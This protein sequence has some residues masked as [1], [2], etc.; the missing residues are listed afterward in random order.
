MLFN[1]LKRDL[2]RKKTMNCILFLFSILVSMFV[3]SGVNNVVTVMN[4]TDYF[5]EKAGIGDY[6][7]ITQNGDGGV[8]DIL[9]NSDNQEGYRIEES[10]F[11]S[12]E[13]IVSE[14]KELNM[15][16]NITLVQSVKNGGINYFLEDNSVLRD[17]NKGEIYVSIALMNKNDLSVGDTIK[18]EIGNI[19]G[20]FKIAGGIK[21]ALMGSEM[22]G[23][24]RIILNDEDYGKFAGDPSVEA[25]KGCIFYIETEN[26]KELSAELTAGKNVLFENG[27]DTIK[28]L[29]VMDMILAIIVLVLSIC[30]IIV[31]FVLLKFVITFTINEEYR[32][33]GVM[34]A[35][36][37][38]NTKIRGLYMI[39]YFFI[40]VAGGL[41]G[42]LL[43]IPFGNMLIRAASEKMY[44]GND[45]GYIYNIA[46][47]LIVVIIMVGFAYICTGKV[48]K[49]SPVD[50]IRNGHTGERFKKKTIYSLKKA[51]TSSVWYMAINDILSAPKRFITIVA[52]FFLCSIFVLGIVLVT[53]TMNS[54]NLITL[55]GKESDVYIPDSGLVK[56]ESM[57]EGGE[58]ILDEVK[59]DISNRLEKENMPATVSIEVWYKYTCYVDGEQYSLVLQKNSGTKTE[60]YEYIEG[61]APENPDEIAIT[62]GISEKTGAQIG[63][64]ITIDFG[65][66]KKDCMVV[67]YFQSM[68]QLGQVIRLH[69]DAPTSM[70]NASALM[71][72]QIDFTDNPDSEEIE[73]R[74]ERIKDI[75]D[76]DGVYTAS[77]YC[78]DCIGVVDTMESIRAML[79]MITCIVVILVTVLMEKSFTSDERGQIALL[80]AIGFKDKTIIKWHVTR[81]F[82]VGL[83]AELLALALTMPVTALWCNPIWKMAGAVTVEY[84]FKPISILVI[85][86][87]IIIAITLI[88][89]YLTA[90]G[91]RRIK[92][93]DIVNVE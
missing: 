9:D 17:V 54:E 71:A 91:T 23:N 45:S 67:G 88:S 64:I 10:I 62:P 73:K 81:F 52:S 47:A 19:S 82:I 27:R 12:K 58:E 25:Y 4:G 57:S 78:R 44:L 35:I 70:K 53:D 39:K 32:E 5:F 2:K 90:L 75:Y 69:Q 79:L 49:S 37:I 11:C 77:G 38:K 26:A 59:E 21:D 50:A 60:D 31:S 48:K 43:S 24:I 42:F 33:I 29:Y 20:E 30:L 74:V 68:N 80:K 28:L 65:N 66:E 92:S 41:I 13:D 8:T 40:A 15:K 61:S 55:F 18:I 6:I 22:M 85:Y 16:N 14:E 93:S 56:M 7:I 1:I 63:D 36:G 46:G 76:I 86:P 84:Y 3:S 72:Y 87:G 51:H 89:A 34:K 83:V